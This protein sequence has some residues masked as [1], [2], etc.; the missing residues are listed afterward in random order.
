MIVDVGL[1]FNYSTLIKQ[2]YLAGIKVGITIIIHKAI[3]LDPGAPNRAVCQKSCESL[4][5]HRIVSNSLI[6]VISS[7]SEGSD[8]L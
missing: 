7:I 3:K 8:V 4:V 2:S 5:S 1:L 6:K